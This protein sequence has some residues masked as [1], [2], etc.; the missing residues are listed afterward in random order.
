MRKERVEVQPG[1]DG[2]YG[3]VKTLPGS[4]RGLEE[5]TRAPWKTDK[6]DRMRARQR[7]LF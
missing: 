4:E 1:Y 3:M 2:A 5:R 7:S 6:G